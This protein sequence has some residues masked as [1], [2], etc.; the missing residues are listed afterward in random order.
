MLLELRHGV[1]KGD[2]STFARETETGLEYAGSAFV[3]LGSED[4]D[5]FWTTVES[6][7]RTKPAIAMPKGK[8]AAW[9]DPIMRVRAQYLK[10]SAKLRHASLREMIP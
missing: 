6:R 5:R 1:Y 2:H 8:K 9:V 7:S 10:G 4:R 3:T